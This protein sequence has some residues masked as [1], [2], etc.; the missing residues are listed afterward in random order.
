MKTRLSLWLLCVFFACAA[1]SSL[2]AH[3]DTVIRL[4]GSKLVGL[5]EQY[6][7]AELDLKS[8]RIRI[9]SHAKEFSPFLKSLFD[10]PYA[11]EAFASWYHERT[12]L[13]PYLSFHISPKG[14]DF[15]YTILLE[16]DT[17][18]LISM[19]VIIGESEATSRSFPVALS[20]S[21]MSK[22]APK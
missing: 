15:S 13:P 7:P 16:L 21:D 10:Q 1:T 14:K 4:E 3:V 2:F 17:L 22:V 11:F 20:D 19:H 6:Q 8:F 5:P 18:K 9:G 12:I